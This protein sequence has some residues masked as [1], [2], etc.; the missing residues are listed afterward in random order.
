MYKVLKPLR[1]ELPD[2]QSSRTL[3]SDLLKLETIYNEM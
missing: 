3:E 1:M 2:L